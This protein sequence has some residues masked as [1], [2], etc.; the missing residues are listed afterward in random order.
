MIYLQH[1]P[2]PITS[3][4]HRSRKESHSKY[5][6]AQGSDP[7]LQRQQAHPPPPQ[8]E[9]TNRPAQNEVSQAS[10]HPTLPIALQ[11]S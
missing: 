7:C 11:A 9:H 4:Q 3:I 8:T 5:H 10:V 1:I 2:G 6:L